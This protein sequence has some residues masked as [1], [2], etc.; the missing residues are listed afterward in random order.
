MKILDVEQNTS[1]WKEMRRT[2][3]GASDCPII[4]EV[5]PYKKPIQLWEEKMSGNSSYSTKAMKRGQEL[6]PIVRNMTSKNHGVLYTPIVVE[7][8]EFPW[9]IASLDGYDEMTQRMIEIKCPNDET[10]STFVN[11]GEEMMDWFYQIQHQL[12][13]TGLNQCTLVLFNGV[14]AVEKPI[15]RDEEVIQKIIQK[16]KE[17]YEC[18]TT[19][20]PPKGTLPTIETAEMMEAVLAAIEVRDKMSEVKKELDQLEE[21]YKICKEG[22]S[23]LSN[24]ISFVCKD[25]QIK[26]IISK[27]SV[28]YSKVEEI[29][30]MDLSRYRKPPRVHWA[31]Y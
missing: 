25:Y 3:I 10:F 19:Y 6:E 30:G 2:R 15:F 1:A 24:D 22:L 18:M 23:F 31:I 9:M 12:C 4:C 11:G 28:D 20:T 5:S 7:H 29:K 26:K 16:E 21:E 8:D 17:F 27:G 13:V 14:Y